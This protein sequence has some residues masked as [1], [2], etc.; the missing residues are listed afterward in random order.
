MRFSTDNYAVGGLKLGKINMSLKV[1][2]NAFIHKLRN[3]ALGMADSLGLWTDE[4]KYGYSKGY[5]IPTFQYH[6]K[7]IDLQIN[8]SFEYLLEKFSGEKSNNEFAF[9]PDIRIRWYATPRLR[10][11]LG[12]SSV[13]EALD[14]SRFYRSL[15]L[16]DFQYI[17]KGYG[18]YAHDKSKA[19]NFGITY[20]DA[21]RALHIIANVSRDFSTSPFAPIR[22]FVGDYIILSAVEQTAK[23]RS[24]QSN[25]I[26]SKGLNLWHGIFNLRATY[27][28]TDASMMQN[29]EREDYISKILNLHSSFDFSFRRNMHLRYGVTFGYNAMDVKSMAEKTFIRNY[30]HEI[31]LSV[32]IDKMIV[33]MNNEYYHNE[34]ISG[35]FKDF[36]LS[37]IKAQYK[38]KKIDID[39]S[40]R[41]IFNK[42]VYSNVIVRDLVSSASINNIR[43]RELMLSV[44]YHL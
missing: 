36:F 23:T 31:A 38:L 37:D 39:L 10:L 12:A 25:L 27:L 5:V 7:D 30:K 8:P 18:G 9:M 4:S 6:T 42:R 29:G 17:N 14:A 44:Y 40:L 41:N 33:E 13:V 19:V 34:R 22:Q 43:A 11:S 32:P 35:G 15:I 21:M 24:W 3:E 1:G 2:V 26:F 16:Q 20:N 28:D